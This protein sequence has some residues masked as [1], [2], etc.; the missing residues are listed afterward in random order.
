MNAMKSKE[1]EK[2]NKKHLEAFEKSL[3]DN[4]LSKKTID[5]HV[6]NVDFYING[7]L[8]DRLEK[9]VTCGCYEVD[10][11]LGDWFI[12]KALWSSCA[13]IKGNAASL[14]KFYAFMLENGAVEQKDYDA[15]CCTIKEEMPA[16]LEAMERFEALADDEDFYDF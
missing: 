5:N 7:Y 1:I 2:A 10:G 8:C 9:D 11:F 6:S 16:W 3:R 15:L 4:G 12:R 14:K 13:H